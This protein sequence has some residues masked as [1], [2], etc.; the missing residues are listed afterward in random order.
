MRIFLLLA[1]AVALG[2]CGS[3]PPLAKGNAA[4]G[5]ATFRGY[6]AVCH[7]ADSRDRKVGPGLKGL[8][9]RSATSTGMKPSEA[10]IRA[11][12]ENGGGGMPPFKDTLS[13]MEMDD[14]MAYLETL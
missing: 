6:C 8:F 5:Q 4:S 7:N 12:I 3:A 10:N 2:S 11:K 14:L 1:C 13:G 9:H